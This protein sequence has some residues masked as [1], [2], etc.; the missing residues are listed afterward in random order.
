M[1]T[2]FVLPAGVQ[3]PPTVTTKV[4]D[5]LTA[6]KPYE[7]GDGEKVHLFRDEKSEA[8]YLTCHLPGAVLAESCDS[9]ATLGVDE[10]DEIYKLNRDI[11]EDQAA[12]QVMEQDAR[13][14]RSFEDLVL[15]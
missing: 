6:F 13:N 3:P 7:L 2:G 1:N 15:E 9:D 4:D 11:Q 8:F 10:E 12:Y 5:F 14:G